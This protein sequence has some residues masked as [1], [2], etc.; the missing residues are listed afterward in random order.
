MVVSIKKN[1][2]VRNDTKHVW[3]YQ[4]FKTQNRRNFS[5]INRIKTLWCYLANQMLQ[6]DSPLRVPGELCDKNM[7]RQQ[8]QKTQHTIIISIS[9]KTNLEVFSYNRQIK[10]NLPAKGSHELIW[11]TDYQ[12]FRFQHKTIYCAMNKLNCRSWFQLMWRA[13]S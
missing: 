3:I 7:P 6:H 10:W 12:H 9:S 2:K 8:H 13:I 1:H 5:Y 4:K 11:Q